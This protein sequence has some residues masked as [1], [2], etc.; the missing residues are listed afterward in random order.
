M[1]EIY[2]PGCYCPNCIQYEKNLRAMI[3]AEPNGFRMKSGPANLTNDVKAKLNS[4]LPI[5]RQLK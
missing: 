1:C 3:N 5:D 4:V 2:S